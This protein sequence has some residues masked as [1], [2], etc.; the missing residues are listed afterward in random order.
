VGTQLVERVRDV[1]APFKS[2]PLNEDLDA[3][4]L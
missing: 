1:L 3:S 4:F 2:C